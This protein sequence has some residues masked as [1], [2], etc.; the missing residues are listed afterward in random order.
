MYVYVCVFVCERVCVCVCVYVCVFV[1]LSG[2]T[3]ELIDLIFG[4]YIYETPGSVNSYIILTYQREI[5]EKV[6][7]VEGISR[8]I[9]KDERKFWGY[10]EQ[11]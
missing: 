4:M 1:P 9:K 11:N 2:L 6:R 7:W 10:A 3:V 8:K 5:P